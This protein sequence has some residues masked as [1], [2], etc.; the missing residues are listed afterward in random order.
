MV[1]WT[2]IAYDKDQAVDFHSFEG[3]AIDALRDEGALG[4]AADQTLDP[5]SAV[6]REEIRKI[7]IEELREAISGLKI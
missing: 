6:M 2:R 7:I 5:D 4:A 3:L 1:N